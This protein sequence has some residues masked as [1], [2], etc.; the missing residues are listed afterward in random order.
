MTPWQLDP[1]ETSPR[2]KHGDT[3]QPMSDR[4]V[5]EYAYTYASPSSRRADGGECIWYR[6]HEG[7]YDLIRTGKEGRRRYHVF[8]AQ[9]GEHLEEFTSWDAGHQWIEERLQSA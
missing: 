6:S 9:S 1:P 7:S 8:D 2:E 5:S 3:I 4:T